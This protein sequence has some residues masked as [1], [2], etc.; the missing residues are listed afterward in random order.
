MDGERDSKRAR[1]ERREHEP[2]SNE[3]GNGLNVVVHAMCK[4]A[5]VDL[6]RKRTVVSHCFIAG[7]L[8]SHQLYVYGDIFMCPYDSTLQ[9]TTKISDPLI[10]I[11]FPNQN[12]SSNV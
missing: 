8:F 9:Y 10:Q 12:F 1:L 6:K 3:K 7:F 2:I 4:Q 5:T 11:R